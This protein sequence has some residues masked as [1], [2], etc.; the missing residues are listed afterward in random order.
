MEEIAIRYLSQYHLMK[1]VVDDSRDMAA[2]IKERTTKWQSVYSK[3]KDMLRFIIRNKIDVSVRVC[4]LN[5][6]DTINFNGATG[7]MEFVIT[8]FD[9]IFA[10]QPTG[11]STPFLEY[12][13]ESIQTNSDKRVA[14][15]YYGGSQPNEPIDEI[16]KYLFNRPNI[17][18]DPITLLGFSSTEWMFTIIKNQYHLDPHKRIIF[19]EE[20]DET[21]MDW[22]NDMDLFGE[23]SLIDVF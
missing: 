22:L 5:R 15:Y 14:R 9:R 19:V 7:D 12:L 18:N 23:T 8:E 17:E 11:S 2:N 21:F 1:F 3:L 16:Q 6:L 4:F 13:K 20:E 10:I